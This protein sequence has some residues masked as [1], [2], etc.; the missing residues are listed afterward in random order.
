MSWV[1][2]EQT[3]WSNNIWLNFPAVE[4][5]SRSHFQ[6]AESTTIIASEHRPIPLTWIEV[7]TPLAKT[8][9]F[10]ATDLTPCLN[11]AMSGALGS[12]L[13]RL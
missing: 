12:T 4:D 13:D 5:R 10:P 2:L 6:T 8:E 9:S 3:Y 11:C 7:T 1:I